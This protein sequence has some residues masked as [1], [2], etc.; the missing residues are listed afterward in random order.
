MTDRY[1]LDLEALPLSTLRLRLE[2]GEVLPGRIILLEDIAERFAT[3]G[4]MGIHTMQDLVDALKTKAR[5][6]SFAQRSGLPRDYL[7]I[8][9]REARSYIP[10]LVNLRDIPGVQAEHV[11]S[12]A[13]LGILHSRHLFGRG[14][15]PGDRAALAASAGVPPESLLE[16]VKL[17]DLARVGGLGPAYVRL[18]YEAGAETIEVL[19][20]QD[21]QALWERAHEVNRELGLTRVVPGLHD[22]VHYVDTA[23]ALAK[24][25]EYE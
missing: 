12:L 22:V 13:A 5:I 8:L 3:L 11:E 19:S 9:G 16:L 25:I 14:R 1:Y 10:K 24:V 7:V 17:S 2:R 21:P 23:K 18:F 4:T 6:G 15:T 20:Q